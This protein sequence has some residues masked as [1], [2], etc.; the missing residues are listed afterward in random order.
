MCV[1]KSLSVA[2]MQRLEIF[3]K[4]LFYIMIDFMVGQPLSFE[5]TLS[6]DSTAIRAKPSLIGCAVYTLI[7]KILLEIFLKSLNHTQ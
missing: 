4:L 7:F 6:L 2:V 3:K 1:P 5:N